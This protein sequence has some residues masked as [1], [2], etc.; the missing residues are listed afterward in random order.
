MKWLFITIFLSGCTTSLVGEWTGEC[1]FSDAN[2]EA[3]LDVTALVDRDNGFILEG[4]MTIVDWNDDQLTADLDG[5]HS[6]K[7]VLF[8]SDF[9][10][11]LGYYRFR[12]ESNR[13]GQLLEGDCTVQT[14]DAPGKLTGHIVLDR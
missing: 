2:S 7:Y 3:T 10:T 11:L 9:E 12:I 13:V 8:K 14:P 4:Q 5:D 1:E 6:G